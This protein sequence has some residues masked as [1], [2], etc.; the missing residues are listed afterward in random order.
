MVNGMGHVTD[1]FRTNGFVTAATPLDHADLQMLRSICNQLLDEPP[2][3]GGE[4]LHNIGLGR[5]RQ[6]LRHRHPDFPVLK[7]FLLSGPPGKLAADLLGDEAYL[8][9]EQFVVKGPRTGAAFAWHQDGAYVGFDHKNYLTVWIALD[10][11]TEANGC[12]YILPRNLEKNPGSVPI[13]G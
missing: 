7:D 8:F 11:A 5:R 12:V 1:D 6:F 3:D 10:D 9:N 2:I 13:R 4:G